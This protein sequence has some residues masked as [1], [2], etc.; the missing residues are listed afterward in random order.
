MC[1]LC[2]SLYL[3]NERTICFSPWPV[4][5]NYNPRGRGGW[6][7]VYVSVVRYTI[8]I[9]LYPLT[10]AGQR[11]GVV[12]VFIRVDEE[13]EEGEGSDSHLITDMYNSRNWNVRHVKISSRLYHSRYCW[14]RCPDISGRDVIHVLQMMKVSRNTSC[15]T[16]TIEN[17]FFSKDSGPLNTSCFPVSYLYVRKNTRTKIYNHFHQ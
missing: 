14:D 4:L 13:H 12:R 17:T 5:P 10:E 6:G 3:L 2:L 15:F 16:D 9:W 1:S 11:P 7:C 8:D